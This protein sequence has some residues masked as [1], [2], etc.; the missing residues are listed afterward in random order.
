MGEILAINSIRIILVFLEGILS[1]FSPCVLP[2]LPVYMSYLAGNTTTKDNSGISFNRRKV[3][4]HTLCFILGISFAFFLLG[5]SFTTL[6]RF[7]Q[8]NK[9]VFARVSGILIIVLGL[10]QLGLFR[11][12]FLQRERKIQFDL[13]NKEVNPIIAILLGFTFSFAWTPCIGPALSSVLML[14]SGANTQYL[15]NLLVFIYTLGFVIPFLFL[16]LFTT[17]VLSFFKRKQKLL[18][19]TIKAGGI[20]L[21]LIGIMTFTGLMNGFSTYFNNQSSISQEFEAENGESL[22]SKSGE[23]EETITE[24][25]TTKLAPSI[26]F[27]LIDQYNKEH[28][29]SDYKG[30]VVFLNFYATWCGPCLD[31]MPHIEELYKEYGKNQEDVVFLG[32]ANPKSAEYP[33]NSDQKE[34]YIISFL[35]KNDFTFPT[36]FDTTSEVFRSYYISAFPTTFIIDEEGDIVDYIVGGMEKKDMKRKIDQVLEN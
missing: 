16:G 24:D 35:D 30:K 36:V 9:V 28:T 33:N 20:L 21:I 11:I 10:F 23:K 26:D 32:V 15:G 29:L 27:T 5:M 1:F 7:F 22:E 8:S 31:E 4:L 6:G 19:I 34:D 3:F 25:T 17:Q 2:L 13:A 12:P 14:A 18:R